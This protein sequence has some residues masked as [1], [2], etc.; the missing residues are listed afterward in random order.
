MCEQVYAKHVHTYTSI[1]NALSI[2]ASLIYTKVYI[3]SNL[4]NIFIHILYNPIFTNNCVFHVKI[5]F[6]VNKRPMGPI[7][8]KGTI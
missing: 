7:C 6:Q 1:F 2:N 4:I 8:L 3:K 5:C